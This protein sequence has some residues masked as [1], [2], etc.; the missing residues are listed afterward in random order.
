MTNELPQWA[1]ENKKWSAS[2]IQSSAKFALYVSWGFTIFWNLISFSPFLSDKNVLAE[3]D[4]N[5]AVALVFLFP[6][7]GIGMFVYSISVTRQWRRFGP[8]PLMLDPFP[9]SI[10][11]HIGGYID[12]RLAYDKDHRCEVS[13]SCRKSYISGSG[14]NRSR[15][16]SVKW[17]SEGFCHVERGRYGS[18][19]NF[20]FAIPEDLPESEEQNS[21]TYILWKVSLHVALDGPDLEREFEIPVFRTGASS[22]I[23]SS[24]ENHP[25]TQDAVEEGIYSIAQITTLDNGVEA[26]FPAL[27]RPSFGVSTLLFGAIFAGAGLFAGHMGAPVIFPILFTAIGVAIFLAG[28]FYLAK[29]LQAQ[30]TPSGVR[31]RRFLFG[32]PVTTR[33]LSKDQIKSIDIKDG[34][35]MQVGNKTTI[36]YKVI[37]KDFNDKKVVL[38]ERLNK[39]AE[40]ERL[41]DMYKT[42]LGL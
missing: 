25:L 35:S 3:F 27:Q 8:T 39:R 2:G 10:G 41:I 40:A 37:A 18:R 34:A 15:K 23:A 13:V 26:Y 38:G 17:Q 20:R 1:I 33:E 42:Y 6:L 21:G 4:R 29:A 11:G 28:V 31:A 14:K 32:Y 9:G 12:T 24:S 5:P 22:S 16:E 7:I 36:L 30:V 19:F